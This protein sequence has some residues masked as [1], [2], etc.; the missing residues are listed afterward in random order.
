MPLSRLPF[1]PQLDG[2]RGEEKT[3]KDKQDHGKRPVDLRSKIY[4]RWVLH[5]TALVVSRL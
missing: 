3:G 4:N 5:G 1:A 2:H